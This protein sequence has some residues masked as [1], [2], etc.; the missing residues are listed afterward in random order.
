[1][2]DPKSKSTCFNTSLILTKEFGPHID[3]KILTIQHIF[4]LPKQLVLTCMLLSIQDQM[5][6]IVL[7]LRPNSFPI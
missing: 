3:E 6:V 5:I 1:M 4:L 2:Q 7:R